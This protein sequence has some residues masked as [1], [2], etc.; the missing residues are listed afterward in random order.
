MLKILSTFFSRLS[1][2]ERLVLYGAIFFISVALLDRL[3]LGPILSKVKSLNKEI[4]SQEALSKK[5]LHILA[6]KD[7]IIKEVNRYASYVAHAQSQEEEIIFLLKEIE[8]MAN[9]SSVYVIDIKSTGLVEE[10]ILKKYLVKL[11]CEAQMEQLTKFFYD[12][13]NSNKLLKIEKYDIR[14][15]TEGSS[16]L[17]CTASISK[18]VLP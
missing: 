9:K 5:S 1:K 13:E 7:R 10:G 4:Q 3:M 18:A 16:V 2:R 15:K 6:Q 14:P 11:N 12:V 17:R 8:K